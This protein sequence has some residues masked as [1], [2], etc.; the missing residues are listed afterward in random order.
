MSSYTLADKVRKVYERALEEKEFDV[1]FIFDWEKAKSKVFFKLINKKRYADI[2]VGIPNK[3]VLDLVMVFYIEF[4]KD[5]KGILIEENLLKNWN[6]GIEELEHAAL[7]NTPRM[8]PASFCTL[9]ELHGKFVETRRPSIEKL[10]VLTNKN[11][12]FGAGAIFYPNMI[13]EI[14]TRFGSD[15]YVIP[16][17]VH[18]TLIWPKDKETE[19]DIKKFAEVISEINEA[20]LESNAFLSDSV[21]LCSKEHGICCC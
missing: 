20:L 16:S 19:E 2:L 7:E 1:T 8:M 12:L 6:I 10:Y 13:D 17:S 15:F 18:E 21:Y 9:D 14:A 3:E 5:E 4:H 11:M